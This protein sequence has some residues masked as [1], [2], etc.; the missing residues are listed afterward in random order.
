MP[1]D[2]TTEQLTFVRV[3]SVWSAMDVDGL[4]DPF[5]LKLIDVYDVTE[6]IT[7]LIYIDC[8]C[9]AAYLHSLFPQT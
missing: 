7:P 5:G 3:M 1:Y 6:E 2:L 8:K 4:I 9:V